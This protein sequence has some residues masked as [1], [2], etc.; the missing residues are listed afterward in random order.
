MV[1][2]LVQ[3]CGVTVDYGTNLLKVCQQFLQFFSCF[4]LKVTFL[5]GNLANP[6]SAFVAA[7]NPGH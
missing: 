6:T 2:S 7:A 4:T 5:W 1:F 3:F